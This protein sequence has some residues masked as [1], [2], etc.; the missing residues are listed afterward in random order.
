MIREVGTEADKKLRE[1]SRHRVDNELRETV[2]EARNLI[3]EKVENLSKPTSF[4][5]KMPSRS[6][7]LSSYS[8]D[9]TVK[10]GTRCQRHPNKQ[11]ERDSTPPNTYLSCG[12]APNV[13]RI[14]DRLRR[15]EPTEL[16]L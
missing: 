7:L 3:Y 6:A 15:N 4:P 12:I 9:L 11:P 5:P 16:L 8:N 14:L 1:T 10:R 13:F 2:A